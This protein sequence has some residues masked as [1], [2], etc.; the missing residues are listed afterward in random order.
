MKGYNTQAVSHPFEED[1]SQV[2]NDYNV[3]KSKAKLPFVIEDDGYVYVSVYGQSNAGGQIPYSNPDGY[4]ENFEYL[5]SDLFMHDGA[6]GWV[7]VSASAPFSPKLYQTSLMICNYLIKKYGIKIRI[8]QRTASSTGINIWD[9]NTGWMFALIESEYA[10]FGGDIRPASIIMWSQ[11]ETNKGDSYAVYAPQF[12]AWINGAIAAGI[13]NSNYVLCLNEI[14]DQGSPAAVNTALQQIADENTNYA[15]IQTD[16]IT[17]MDGL[18]WEPRTQGIVEFSRRFIN[19]FEA[20]IF[21]FDLPPYLNRPTAPTVTLDATNAD[22]VDISWTA[23]TA[24]EAGATI[25][26]YRLTRGVE[27]TQFYKDA[28]TTLSANIPFTVASGETEKFS[29]FGKD[30]N[31]KYTPNKDLVIVSA[32]RP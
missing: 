6:G 3:T 32:T 19:A 26:S 16:G 18:H 20:L 15:F 29:V 23:S 24:T 1:L 21:G 22:S 14:N 11:G 10:A 5:S 27:G 2:V 30:S 12:Y 28:G 7:G 25:L 8:Y 31:G 9:P 17:Q 13:I 4:I